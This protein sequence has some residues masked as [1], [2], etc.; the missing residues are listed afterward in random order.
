M[1]AN[2]DEWLVVNTIVED[3]RYLTERFITSSN[4]KKETDGAKWH[5]VPCEK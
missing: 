4:F 3:S 2:G 5:P 1:L